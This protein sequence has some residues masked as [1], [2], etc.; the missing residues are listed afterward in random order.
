MPLITCIAMWTWILIQRLEGLILGTSNA[1]VSSTQ[2]LCKNARYISQS[3]F[4]LFSY[5]SKIAFPGGVLPTNLASHWLV[6]PIVI[7]IP[8]HRPGEVVGFAQSVQ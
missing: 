2:G 3:E 6:A 8:I 7:G 4:Y 1:L 5:G